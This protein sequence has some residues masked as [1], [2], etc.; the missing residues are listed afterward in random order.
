MLR[1]CESEGCERAGALVEKGRKR[2]EKRVEVIGAA[3]DICRIVGTYRFESGGKLSDEEV[4]TAGKFKTRK[5]SD[6]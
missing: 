2:R 3:K 6:N 5:G 1:D 4:S